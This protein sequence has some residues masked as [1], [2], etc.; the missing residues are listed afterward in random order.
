MKAEVE[1]DD[2]GSKVVGET[3]F[4]VEE[5][6]LPSF[7]VTFDASSMPLYV[8]SSKS[9]NVFTGRVESSYTYGKHGGRKSESYHQ[10]A[11]HFELLLRWRS[12]CWWWWW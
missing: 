2:D 3:G 6:V 10:K 11:E 8:L 12:C 5:Y 9:A 4:N 7:D 1:I